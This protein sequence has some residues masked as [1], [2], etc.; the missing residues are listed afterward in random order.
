MKNY[1][2][3]MMAILAGV[4]AGWLLF[5]QLADSHAQGPAPDGKKVYIV[6]LQN[7]EQVSIAQD[8]QAEYEPALNTLSRVV[9]LVGGVTAA[10]NQR[11]VPATQEE[12]IAYAQQTAAAAQAAGAE[13]QE[14]HMQAVGALEAAQDEMRGEILARSAKDRQ[15]SQNA[16]AQ[17]VEALGGEVIYR[18][19]TIN[20]MAVKLSPAEQ[21][22][23]A[24]QPNVAAIFEDQLTEGHMNVSAYAIG[25][26]TWW[27]SGYDGGVWDAAVIDSGIDDTHPALSSQNFSERRCL[28]A[29]GNPSSDPTA[30]DRNGHGTHIAGTIASTNS[31]YRGIA[32][33]LDYLLNGKAAF[34]SGGN[35][36]MYW[37]D[38]M[39]CTDWALDTAQKADVINLS[40]GGT[41][42]SDDGGYERFWDAVVDQMYAVVTISAGNSGP[43][44]NTI[45]SPS[46]AYN[47]ISVANINDQNTIPRSD[48][49]IYSSSSRGPTPAGRKKPDLAAPGSAIYSTNYNWE[50]S[51]YYVNYW[52]TSMAAPH[53]AGAATL[54][55]DAGVTDPMAVKALLINTAEDKGTTGWDTAYGWGYINLTHLA[56][57]VT[58]YFAGSVAPSPAYKF[59]AGPAYANDL[60]T[61][62]WHRR[63]VYNNAAYPSTYYTLTD[64]DLYL[65]NEATNTTLGSSLSG[66]DNV[67]QVKAGADYSEVVVKI[68]SWS[69]SIAGAGTEDY[70]LATEE[71]FSAKAGPHLQV[72]TTTV[73]GDI[74]GPAGTVLNVSVR[75]QNNGDLR[76]H[77]VFLNATYGDGLTR[78]SGNDSNSIGNLDDGSSSGIYSWQFTKTDDDPQ[79][80]RLQATSSSYEEVFAGTWLWGGET[81]YLPIIMRNN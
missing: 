11:P 61:L 65:Y 77:S 29:A 69:G 17:T 21:A 47:V 36:W 53:V 80:V 62:V 49:V 14:A 28:A 68:D 76:A 34:N 56:S 12:E 13:A 38:G 70:V 55:M 75:V 46:I 71:G 42:S 50:T 32:Y 58:D 18:Y 20:A 52:G 60:A 63:A 16:V 48:D 1:T 2:R 81:V 44:N 26:D 66:I 33:G 25:A 37:S 24:A 78:N 15:A 45:S 3:F 27:G 10:Q 9:Q 57:H 79:W 19:D 40:Y 54:V 23:L 35:A 74:E 31:T 67:E 4:V 6:Y 41:A 43:N 30:D 7:Q 5:H 39:A 73:T 59:Y 22:A 72:I 51:S 8:V 64:L